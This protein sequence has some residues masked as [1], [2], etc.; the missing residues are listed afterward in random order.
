MQ[1]APVRTPAQIEVT[2]DRGVLWPASPAA[3]RPNPS[4]SWCSDARDTQGES[5]MSDN[6]QVTGPGAEQEPQRA[7]LPAVDVFEDAGSITLLADMPGVPKEQLELKVEGDALLIEGA[8]P[9]LAPE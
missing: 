2:L 1:L 7:V 8:A 6:K 3:N 9:R 5:V 4:A